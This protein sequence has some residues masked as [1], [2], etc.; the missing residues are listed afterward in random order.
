VAKIKLHF[1]VLAVF[2]GVFVTAGDDLRTNQLMIGGTAVDSKVVDGKIVG[3]KWIVV[4]N[5]LIRVHAEITPLQGPPD[6][7]EVNSSSKDDSEPS[8][9]LMV[10]TGDGPINSSGVKGLHGL[11]YMASDWGT[12]GLAQT[13]R[14][15]I[16]ATDDKT[17]IVVMVRDNGPI[18]SSTNSGMA[19]TVINT[20]GKYQFPLT[21]GPDGGGFYAEATLYP[22]PKNQTP[23]NTPVSNWYA[24]GSAPDGSKLVMTS[25]SSQPAPVLSITL[26]GNVVIVSWPSSFTGFILQQNGDLTA[27]NWVDVTNAASVVGEQNQVIMSPTNSNNFYRLK[28]Q[29]P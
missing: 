13:T 1:L 17:R 10:A 11:I 3:D 29:S 23:T 26:S 19:W 7:P 12:P 4:S 22:S 14:V 6:A 20:P 8:L 25:D 27:T 18:Y 9:R 21:S 15:D 5:S 2:G 24:V 16:F 28:S